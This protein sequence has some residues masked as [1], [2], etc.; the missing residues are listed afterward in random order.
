MTG[1]GDVCRDIKSFRTKVDGGVEIQREE[2]VGRGRGTQCLTVKG[3]M[4][5]LA[6]SSF[7]SRK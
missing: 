6:P 4:A 7:M 5:R 1:R 2:L 3:K